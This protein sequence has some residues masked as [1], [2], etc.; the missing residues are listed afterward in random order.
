MS[1]D[2]LGGEHGGELLEERPLGA[3]L[4]LDVVDGVDAQDRRVLLVAERGTGAA[5]DDVALAQAELAHLL[6]RH[7]AVVLRRQQAVDPEE[8][9]AVVAQVEQPTPGWAR[10]CTRPAG[11]RC[12]GCGPGDGGACRRR[13]GRRRPGRRCRCVAELAALVVLAPS[14]LAPWSSLP[15]AVSALG[16]A[17]VLAA[18]SCVAGIGLAP[19]EPFA[20]LAA[21]S[22]SFDGRA[23]LRRVGL[24][25]VLSSALARPCRAT[26]ARR[27]PSSSAPRP[28]S[29]PVT[30]VSS[31]IWSIRSALRVRV[32]ALPPSAPTIFCSSSR[33]LR[34]SVSRSRALAST[35]I[36]I[37]CFRQVLDQAAARMADV[38]RGAHS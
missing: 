33:S 12:R 36:V 38:A 22:A 13:P 3:G 30:P 5:G 21:V 34:S 24:A 28:C 19:P 25:S 7:V 20:G 8:A 37:R 4:E 27:R 15:R 18:L 1:V 23:R 14:F 17:V 31:R 35:L 9:V 11:A 29:A 6:D 26:L 10:R 2:G 32:V 16:G